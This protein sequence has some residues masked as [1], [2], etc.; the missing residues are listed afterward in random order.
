MNVETCVLCS[1]CF[2]C[3][4]VKIFTHT[5]YRCMIYKITD[6]SQIVNIIHCVINSYT[7]TTVVYLNNLMPSSESTELTALR[8][9]YAQSGKDG[10]RGGV[11]SVA[12][13][14]PECSGGPSATEKCARSPGICGWLHGALCSTAEFFFAVNMWSF[15]KGAEPPLQEPS[16]PPTRLSIILTAALN[17]SFFCRQL[18]ATVIRFTCTC[19]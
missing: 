17:L 3:I 9:N 6:N 12:H 8:Y 11:V 2:S 1:C 15:L 13:R 16:V 7:T 19:L 14:R 5:S 10:V 4:I 18:Q